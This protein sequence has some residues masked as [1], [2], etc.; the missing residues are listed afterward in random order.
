MGFD[1]KCRQQR[2]KRRREWGRMEAEDRQEERT[3][4]DTT[5]RKRREE[6]RLGKEEKMEAEEGEKERRTRE[7]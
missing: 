5:W 2:E 6:R 4:C 7:K 3:G 1:T